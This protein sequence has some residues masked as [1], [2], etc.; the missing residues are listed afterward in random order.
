MVNECMLQRALHRLP[1][2][3]TYWDSITSC[4]AVLS[5]LAMSAAMAGRLGASGR[6]CSSPSVLGH[7]ILSTALLLAD[8]EKL[9]RNQSIA[10]AP[11][12][13]RVTPWLHLRLLRLLLLA[14]CNYACAR[15]AAC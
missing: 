2:M 6:F 7:S 12:R 4:H 14:K 8:V 10:N 5:W 11:R 13:C 15:R 9:K 1:D 3:H